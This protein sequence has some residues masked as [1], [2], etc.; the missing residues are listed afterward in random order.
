MKDATRLIRAGLPQP[1]QGAP[2]LPG[3]VFAAPFHVSGDPADAAYGYGREEHPTWEAYESALGELEGGEAVLFG[4]G[5]AA[6]TAVLLTALRP[7][8]TLTLPSDCYMHVRELGS[9]YLEERGVEVNFL[10]TAELTPEALPEKVDLLWLETPSNPGLELCDIRALAAAGHERGA[11]V[12]VDN[13]LPTPLGQRALELGADLSV[14]SATKHLS[15]HSDLLLGYV[16][17]RD[18]ARADELRA[19]R[20][21]TGSIAGPFE[22]WLAHR[23]LATLDVRL[24]RGEANA[25]ALAEML[26]DRV[27]GVRYPGLPSDPAHELA[28]RQMTRFGTV[29]CFDL[30]SRERAEQF[31]S[32]AELVTDATSF[33]GV[34]TMA[35][36]R[37]RW[38][39][40]DVPE[41]FIRLSAGCEATDD[42]LADVEQALA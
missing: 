41:G 37:V 8:G 38:G 30:G 6:C 5:M 20:T 7:G 42:L 34:I 31:L 33:G 25:R 9:D 39:G 35:E 27:E 4:S 18:R 26:A 19:W 24:E 40:D 10:P 32:T 17:A 22:T 1:E 2:F 29:L 28:K 16:A 3:P 11:V 15:G 12:A 21:M 14:T 13:T 36:R 23:S